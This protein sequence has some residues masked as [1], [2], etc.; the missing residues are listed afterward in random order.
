MIL[1]DPLARPVIA[2][3]GASG[4]F[5]E[6]TLLAFR[7]AV[8]AG[9]DAI[10]LDV[11]LCGDGVPVVIHDD[12]VERTTDG[13]G[14]VHEMRLD[15]LRRLDAGA[16]ETVP[17][18][19]EVFE[20]FPDLPVIVEIKHPAASGPVLEV[21]R[22]MGCSGR[23]LVGSF[24][25]SSLRVFRGARIAT[26]ASRRD[27]AVFWAASRTG[28]IKPPG[29]YRAFTVP[30]YSNNLRVV[31]RRFTRLAERAGKPVHVWTV[32]DQDDAR[33]LWDLGVAGVITNFPRRMHPGGS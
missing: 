12:T 14:L 21:L 27:S 11:H 23:V 26:S 30:E 1:L 29:P 17:T 10:E 22:R 3:R 5:P 25:H 16:G 19:A 13:R 32:D 9:A 33:R 24:H 20:V 6:N 7:E 31:D 2:H 18:L 28:W 4:R 15:V 8:A